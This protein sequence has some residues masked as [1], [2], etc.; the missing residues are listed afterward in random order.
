MTAHTLPDAQA[1]EPTALRPAQLAGLAAAVF[2]V[3]AGYGALMPLVPGWPAPMMPG[4]GTA[5]VARHVGFLSGV[6]ATGVR[7][8]AL[9]RGVV[10]DRVEHGRIL[11]GAGLVLAMTGLAVLGQQRSKLWMYGEVSFASAGTGLVLPVIGY[12]AA[13][14][15][16]NKLGTTMGGL[17]AAAGLGQTLGSAAG[18]WLFG[19]FAQRS[20]AWLT[21]PLL[22]TLLL[23]LARPLWWSGMTAKFSRGA[24]RQL[25]ARLTPDGR[26]GT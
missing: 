11:I 15:S 21:V 10:S 5:E 24:T 23:L 25:T 8:G 17:A 9:L 2:V 7:V 1:T 19:A 26:G 4:A 16:A 18:G 13:G 3:S 20:F 14:A 22:A 6:Y 12:L